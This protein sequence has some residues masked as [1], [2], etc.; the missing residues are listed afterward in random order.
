[1][2]IYFLS[3][4]TKQ[5]FV[6]V[7]GSFG[8]GWAFKTV[9]SLLTDSGSKVYLPTLTGQGERVH[10]AGLNV[11]LDTH[12]N[13]IVNTI[14]FEELRDI[15]LVGHS[16]GGMVVIGVVDK[17]P[18][19]I[20]KMVYIDAFVPENNESVRSING[21]RNTSLEVV[22]GHVVPPWVTKGQEP[23]KDVPH[24]LKTWTDKIILKSEKRLEIPTSYILTVE[25]GKD[26]EK[27]AFASQAKRAK[28]KGWTMFQLEADHN[29]QWSA[30]EEFVKMLKDIEAK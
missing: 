21:N 25:K 8:G 26:P 1:M 22:N 24:P 13:D 3:K 16:Y 10:L 19:R 7:H 12:I 18:E 27:D 6:I 5:V 9:D 4:K 30:P 20:S 29:A 23:P 17:V 11:G 28:A 15:I 14:L 2:S